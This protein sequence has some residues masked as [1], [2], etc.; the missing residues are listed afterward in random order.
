[1]YLQAAQWGFAALD[2]RQLFTPIAGL[3]M[4]NSSAKLPQAEYL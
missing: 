4:T 2:V 1:M 3:A